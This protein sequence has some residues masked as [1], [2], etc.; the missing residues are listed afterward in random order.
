VRASEG[1]IEA[2]IRLLLRRD[3]TPADRPPQPRRYSS[4]MPKRSPILL[5]TAALALAANAADVPPPARTHRD[6]HY[7]IDLPAGYRAPVEHVSGSS[8]SHGFRNPYP[9]GR[10]STVILITVQDMGP[11]FARR[12]AAER[13]ALTRETLQPVLAS[14]EKNRGGF[15]K[16][17]V[18][19][20]TIGGQPGL[21]VGWTGSAQ[22]VAFQGVVFCVLA[23]ARA[24]AVQ[25]QDPA[26][27][28]NARLNEAVRAVER[29]RLSR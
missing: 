10:L 2:L 8:V 29:M 26:G 12:L 14:I 1:F 21:R 17:E 22:G 7:T 25:V 11:G 6:T 9:D 3:N 18:H 27:L 16:G 13:A 24:Y 28:G 4:P 5:L 23:G 15:R 20:V 19:A